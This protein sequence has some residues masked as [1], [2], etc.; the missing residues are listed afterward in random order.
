MRSSIEITNQEGLNWQAWAQ[1]HNVIADDP[2]NTKMVVNFFQKTW[3][4]DINDVNLDK[5]FDNL[6]PHLKF[7]SPAEVEFRSLAARMTVAERDLIA[8]LITSRGLKDGAGDEILT[9]WNTVASYL[10]DSRLS[11]T[12]ENFDIALTRIV[13]GGK[14]PLLWKPRLQAS[15]LEAKQQ[16]EAAKQQPAR[17]KD[18][19]TIPPGLDPKLHDHYRALHRAPRPEDVPKP[20]DVQASDARFKDMAE[21]VSTRSHL[22]N[23]SIKRMFVTKNGTSDIDWQAT[24]RARQIAA[25]RYNN[26]MSQVG[27]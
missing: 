6:R 9:N 20:A 25:E 17:A 22:E 24:Y 12:P 19:V 1:K 16:K 15:E 8:S 18:E 13:S 11:I 7:Y 4:E 2:G 26:R 21:S 10:L 5:A 27:R 14:R 23:A 3:G